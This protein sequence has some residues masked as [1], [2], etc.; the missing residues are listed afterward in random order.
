MYVARCKAGK[1]VAAGIANTPIEQ[2]DMAS[3]VKRWS[4]K[5]TVTLEEGRK[6]D[7]TW[8]FKENQNCKKC[9]EVILNANPA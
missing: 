7:I 6:E 3:D 4:K 1:T 8:C 5:Y 2:A 9:E